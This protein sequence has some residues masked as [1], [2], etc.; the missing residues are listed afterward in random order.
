MS[1]GLLPRE[2]AQPEK[3]KPVEAN[4]TI[5]YCSK[6]TGI[7]AHVPMRVPGRPNGFEL[8]GAGLTP[9]CTHDRRAAGVRCNEWF[10]DAFT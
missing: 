3:K 10:G 2:P 4:Q 7:T 1:R 5:E 8:T 6:D 9:C